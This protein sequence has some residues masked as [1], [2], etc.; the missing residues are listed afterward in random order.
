MN[1][2]FLLPPCTSILCSQLCLRRSL[3]DCDYKTRRQG[4]FSSFS[5]AYWVTQTFSQ[6]LDWNRIHLVERKYI[7]FSLNLWE[8]GTHHCSCCAS[9]IWPLWSLF[10]FS[11]SLLDITVASSTRM[12]VCSFRSP[13]IKAVKHTEQNAT[14]THSHLACWLG[15]EDPHTMSKKS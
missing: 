4:P 6:F 8:G 7:Y 13:K 10:N 5:L 1:A 9:G 11:F 12:K 15:A 3:I 14:I 2:S